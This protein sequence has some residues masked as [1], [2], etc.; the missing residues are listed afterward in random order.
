VEFF[1]MDRCARLLQDMIDEDVLPHVAISIVRS[2]LESGAATLE[3]TE[4]LDW[5]E[6]AVHVCRQKKRSG[7]AMRNSAGLLVKIVKDRETRS[8]VVSPELEESLMAGFRRQREAAEKQHLED[9]ERALILEY[10]QSRVQLAE[11]LFEDMAEDKK[12][13]F[14][15]QKTEALSVQERFQRIPSTV[16]ARE[17]DAA[18]IQEIARKE[19]PPFE[20]WRLRKQAQQAV[21]AFGEPLD[22]LR[23]GTA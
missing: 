7:Q 16:Q 17:V 20:K 6:I 19:A 13:V 8:R 21:L 11:T 3:G 2:A 14:R 5:C 10:E 9:V 1:A 22:Q 23:E 15:K 18:I 12:A 4:L